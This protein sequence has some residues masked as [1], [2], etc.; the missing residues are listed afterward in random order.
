MI[1]NVKKFLFQITNIGFF[2]FETG[3]YLYSFF[4]IKIKSLM[5]S[6]MIPTKKSNTYEIEFIKNGKVGYIYKGNMV[7]QKH[8]LDNPDKKYELYVLNEYAENSTIKNIIFKNVT[9]INDYFFNSNKKE[10]QSVLD[11]NYID[12][13]LEYNGRKYPVYLKKHDLYN[14]YIKHNVIDKE[15]IKYYL[16][17]FL[18]DEN[19]QNECVFDEF[20]TYIL[21]VC[22]NNANFS[23]YT[24][25]DSFIL[26]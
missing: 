9:N 15:F 23:T 10:E 3:V 19:K 26:L 7:F 22:D 21:K 17:N 2:L 11:Y 6:F 5:K 1:M 18:I 13:S 8:L 12:I 4:E 16:I 14:F 24:E 20:F 25:K